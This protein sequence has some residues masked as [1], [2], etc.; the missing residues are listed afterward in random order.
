[1]PTRWLVRTLAA[2]AAALVTTAAG[3]FLARDAVARSRLL[4]RNRTEQPDYDVL[5]EFDGF[6]VRRYPPRLVAEVEV[7]G[8]P[9]R[10]TRDAFTVLAGFVIGENCRIGG[11]GGPI[12]RR[13]SESIAMTAPVDRQRRGDRWVLRF[14]MP[15]KYTRDT[16]PRPL[17]P[18][19]RILEQPAATYAA[20]RFAGV[21]SEGAVQQRLARLCEEVRA[22][23]LAPAGA[24]PILAR[25]DPPW[26]PWFLRRN[27]LLVELR[28]VA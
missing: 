18:R 28:T 22:R 26:T 12:G 2:A 21:G 4:V 17:D 13:S 11:D 10:A 6:E 16:L 19:V 1:M 9:T 8:D 24:E 15:R 14:T 23:G 3:A 7:S 5:Y 20:V 25:Y 27:E